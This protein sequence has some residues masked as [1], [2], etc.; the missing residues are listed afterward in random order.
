MD[1]IEFFNKYRIKEDDF[2]KTGLNWQELME[3]KDRYSDFAPSLKT[4][5]N[6]VSDTLLEIKQVHAVRIR[7][8]DPEHLIEKIIRKKI[9]DHDFEIT[10][11]NYKEKI[12]D[13]I[14]IRALHLFKD[15]WIKIHNSI[16][17]K[18]KPVESPVANIRDGDHE[19]LINLYNEN[20]C[21]INKH[22]HGY[23]SI[24]Y[25]I[26]FEGSIEASI[27]IEI[28]V[29]T[30]FEEAWSEIDHSVRYPYDIENPILNPYLSIFNRLVGSA[31]EMGLFIK[32]LKNEVD[33]TNKKIEEELIKNKKTISALQRQIQ[34]LK[35]DYKEREQLKQKIK[36]LET[37]LDSTR[38]Y[39]THIYS[40]KDF[41]T[42]TPNLS[43]SPDISQF[44]FFEGVDLCAAP[45]RYVPLSKDDSFDE[46]ECT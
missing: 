17:A 8:K 3:I 35:I 40:D 6:Y 23:R 22:I 4:P 16:I 33:N 28:Q 19:E 32:F 42:Y 10:I 34:D 39:R 12:T 15:D 37:Q 1:R 26:S 36:N 29:R 2:T 46:G 38:T 43:A 41:S 31:D 44:R 30:V 13:L 25:L 45:V 11:E 20:G 27:I 18:W 5:A 21:E 14:G 9:Q 7:V 24:H